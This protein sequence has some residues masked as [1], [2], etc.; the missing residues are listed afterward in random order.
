[1]AQHGPA[2][3]AMRHHGPPFR[4]FHTTPVCTRQA[5]PLSSFATKSWNSASQAVAGTS[6]TRKRSGEAPLHDESEPNITWK[7]SVYE[8]HRRVLAV[9]SCL[10]LGIQGHP[11]HW[12]WWLELPGVPTTQ[13]VVEQLS[14]RKIA[15]TNMATH[16]NH[17]SWWNRRCCR[18]HDKDGD[19]AG[20]PL[21]DDHQDQEPWHFGQLVETREVVKRWCNR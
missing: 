14:T 20:T 13:M 7:G 12:E 1:M 18:S 5:V 21:C 16:G 17:H 4:W 6:L 11:S 9:G 10:V 19:E 8:Q 3:A 15:R 2:W